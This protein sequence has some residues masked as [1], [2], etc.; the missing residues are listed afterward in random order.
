MKK[1]MYR[2]FAILAQKTVEEKKATDKLPMLKY[3]II[4]QSTRLNIT[5]RR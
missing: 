4:M 2:L 1:S 3:G 5:E